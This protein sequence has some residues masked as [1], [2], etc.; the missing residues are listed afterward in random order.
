[1]RHVLPLITKKEVISMSVSNPCESVH[2]P[3]ETLHKY[4][5]YNRKGSQI[6]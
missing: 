1:M 5:D 2:K 4:L 3:E 6:I